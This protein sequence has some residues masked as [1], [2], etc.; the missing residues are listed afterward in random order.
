MVGQFVLSPGVGACTPGGMQWKARVRLPPITVNSSP[1]WGVGE[2]HDP[3]RLIK[4]RHPADLWIYLANF[5]QSAP[6]GCD[7]ECLQMRSFD[8][9][10]HSYGILFRKGIS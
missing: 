8:D 2:S 4:P 10:R 7:P 1:E 5:W 6:K 9:V 3:D